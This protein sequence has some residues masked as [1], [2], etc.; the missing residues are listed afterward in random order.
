MGRL[1]HEYINQQQ[2]MCW[3]EWE[4]FGNITPVG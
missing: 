3:V 2:D 4:E 1:N